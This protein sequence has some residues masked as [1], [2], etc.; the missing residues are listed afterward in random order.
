MTLLN[1]IYDLTLQED[2]VT[3]DAKRT[4]KLIKKVLT[5]EEKNDEN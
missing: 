5:R 4:L 3:G 1:L 2:L